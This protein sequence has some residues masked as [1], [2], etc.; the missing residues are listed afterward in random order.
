MEMKRFGEV[1]SVPRSYESTLQSLRGL[2][3]SAGLS[4]VQ[5]IDLSHDSR[6]ELEAG[7]SKCALMIVDCPLLLFEAVALDRS[8]AVLI[9]LHLVLTGNEH[10]TWI[11]WAHPA[12]AFGLRLA[13]TAQG[14]VDALYA[15]LTEVLRKASTRT[16]RGAGNGGCE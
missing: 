10:H 6:V 5:H 1:Q 12:G 11:H 4:V 7:T 16:G 15:R 13:A 2:L 8:A 14:P 9:P 3:R